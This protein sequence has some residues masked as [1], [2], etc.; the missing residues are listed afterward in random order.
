[1][2]IGTYISIITLNVNGLNA[3]TKRYRL[4]ECSD[5][6]ARPIYMLP[7]GDPFQTK[8]HIQIESKSMEKILHVNGN[9]KKAGVAII[10]SDKNRL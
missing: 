6:K 1:M 3:P 7:T 8:K 5:T 9:Q 2:L 10:I 4:T